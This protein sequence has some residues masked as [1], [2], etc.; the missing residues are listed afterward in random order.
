MG[1]LNPWFLA[2]GTAVLVP[3]FLHLFYRRESK[4]FAFPAIRYLLRTERER[5]S[6][7]RAQQLLLLLL[8]GA[9]VVL[10]ALAGAR[11]HL[12]GGA[13]SH[14]PTALALVLDNSMSTTVVDGGRRHLDALK[15]AARVSVAQAGHDDVIW[16]IGAGTPW[17]RAVPGGAAQA[18]AAVDS[19]RPAHGRAEM[20]RVVA[21]ARAL[22]AQS[23]L[24]AG[25]VH[26]FTD[27]QATAFDGVE[28]GAGD[29]SVPVVIFGLPAAGA[30]LQGEADGR[31][32]AAGGGGLNRGVERVVFDGGLAPLAG[33]RAH[34]SALVSGGAPGDTVV[35]RLYVGDQVRAAGRAP[36]GAAATLPA[37]PFRA[38]RIEGWV[39]IDPDPLTADD[40]RY[41]SFAVREPP[42]AALA[43]DAPLFAREALAVLEESGR[44]ALVAPGS[45]EV[46]VSAGG[47]GLEPAAAGRQGST[48]RR[49]VVFP[50][51]DAA[52]L[53]A[54]NRRLAD[55]GIPFRYAAA[56][57]ASGALRVAEHALPV[58]LAGLEVRHR[59]AVEPAGAGPAA[60]ASRVLATLS[61]GDPW[62]LAGVAPQ[63]GSYVLIASPVDEES[64][65]LPV[66]AAMLPLVEWAVEHGAGTGGAGTQGA[67]AGEAFV[68]SP[69]ASTI[70][71]PQGA[72][73][74]VD[75][76]QPFPAATA[77]L[78]R[79]MAGDSVLE[80]IAVNPPAAET[81]LTPLSPAA[82]VQALPG[83]VAVVDDADEWRGEIFRA[84]R[85]LEPWRLLALAL[86]A[87]A[88]VESAA[89]A[90][91]RVLSRT[92]GA[93]APG[94]VSPKSARG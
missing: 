38:G 27:L 75:G 20:A 94:P 43:G 52:L 10:L 23:G 70:V 67:V 89:A 81:D 37:G 90:S 71:D 16:V 77:G 47:E 14:E 56:A 3:L 35:A 73:H 13:G 84:K 15:A 26:V 69:A 24:S 60:A 76:D 45:A 66:S 28:E 42:L 93:A 33:R 57:A 64:T 40:R 86:L 72:P 34:V 11:V 79:V 87:L 19:V 18:L 44:V 41:F 58:D 7:I 31:A 2:A 74:R 68:P 9:I 80:T 83:A 29:P 51:A 54:L 82:L 25:E 12:R 55:A 36:V 61:N 59:F 78:Y 53:P 91:T 5:A 22:V 49:A 85:G 62:L 88:L 17:E 39:E 30:S 8:R 50:L 48:G 21:R 46:L 1:F 4:T 92:Q 65:S 32:R 63:G 6:Q